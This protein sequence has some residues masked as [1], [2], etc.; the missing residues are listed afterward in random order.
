M[1]RIVFVL[2]GGKEDST[3][4]LDDPAVSTTAIIKAFQSK[5]WDA[6]EGFVQR[7]YRRL[8]ATDAFLNEKTQKRVGKRENGEL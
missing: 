1:N 5:K 6:A 8:E 3:I 2:A 4:F 7:R